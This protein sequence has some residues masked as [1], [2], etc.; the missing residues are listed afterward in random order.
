[1]YQTI[2]RQ[3]YIYAILIPGKKAEEAEL[4]IDRIIEEVKSGTLKESEVTKVKNKMESRLTYK[5]QTV[6]SKA[7]LLSHYKMFFNSPGLIDTNINNYAPISTASIT[8]AANKYLNKTNRV[9]LHYLPKKNRK[10]KQQS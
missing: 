6:L 8:E 7:D 2:I 1:M 5:R 9:T 10:A 4:E 3:G